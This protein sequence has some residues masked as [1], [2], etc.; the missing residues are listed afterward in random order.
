MNDGCYLIIW[1]WFV[2]SEGS[3]LSRGLI[4]L[5]EI[6][7]LFNWAFTITRNNSDLTVPYVVTDLVGK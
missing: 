3:N 6:K 7:R 5:A 4:S 2:S 1:V